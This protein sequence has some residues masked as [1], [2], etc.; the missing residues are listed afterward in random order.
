MTE[1]WKFY[2]VDQMPFA[3]SIYLLARTFGLSKSLPLRATG[4]FLIRFF[5]LIAKYPSI[6]GEGILSFEARGKR[7]FAQFTGSYLQF[8]AIYM[9]SYRRGYEATTSA[10]LTKLVPNDG[11]FYDIGSNWGFFSFIIASQPQ[12]QGRV[13]P[14][15]PNPVA[16]K[17]LERI[18]KASNLE[19]FIIPQAYGLGDLDQALT[20]SEES[21]TQTG[22]TK[23]NPLGFG[24][25]KVQ[26]R[27]LD[28]LDLP[29][30]NVIKIDVEG[31]ESKVIEGGQKIIANHKP[32]ILFENWF[33]PD[34][35]LLS[36]KF[37]NDLTSLGYVFFTPGFRFVSGDRIVMIQSDS[38]CASLWDAGVPGRIC[39]VPVTA[40]SRALMQTHLNFLACHQDRTAEVLSSIPLQ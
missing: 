20:I 22:Q 32:H 4:P 19:E 8:R 11:V 14:F 27:K 16:R 40:A 24:V 26:V 33:N 34:N 23:L 38:S 21:K 35:P 3:A 5:R 9:P 6:A 10:I 15:E 2:N 36:N 28:N 12:F 17:D 29:P 30:P 13:F 7:I 18:R 1:N 25:T 39:L 31:M 37:F